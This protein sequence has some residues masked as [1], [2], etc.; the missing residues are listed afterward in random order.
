M[1]DHAAVLA[2]LCYLKNDGK[3]LMMHRVNKDN[4]V[5]EG[6][7]NGLGGKFEP[8]ETPEQCVQREVREEAGVEILEKKLEGLLTF[9]QFTDDCD[10]YVF[11]FTSTDFE[12]QPYEESRE[13]NLKWIDDDKL[14]DLNLWE[15]DRYFLRWLEDPA[16]FS[17]C[18]VYEDGELS[19]YDSNF[20]PV[21]ND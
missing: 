7:W 3:T 21:N 16:F 14:F 4:D 17:A 11:V 2:T 9:P 12:G 15:G 8:G 1:N 10:W 20:Y 6:K 5:H 18:F 19:N 13:G